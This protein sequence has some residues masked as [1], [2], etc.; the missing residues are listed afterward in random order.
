MYKRT[1]KGWLKHLDFILFDELSLQVAFI[2]GYFLRQHVF[3]PYANNTY[4][5]IGIIL[6]IFDL[7]VAVMMDSM[8]NVVKRGYWK[9]F[10]CTVKHCTMVFLLINLWMFS[11]KNADA[12]SRIVLYLTYLFHIAIGYGTRLLWKFHIQHRGVLESGKT[13]MLA[14]LD[15]ENAVGMV[16]RLISMPL[17]GYH[18]VGVVISDADPK[19]SGEF[20]SALPTDVDGKYTINNIPIV[21]SFKEA[22]HYIVRNWVDSV[23]ISCRGDRPEIR[24]FMSKCSEM[25]VTIHY[26]VPSIGRNGS[27][28]FVEK[29]GGST[30][31]TS[32]VNYATPMQLILKRGM[33]IFGGL[34]G[35]MFALI[36]M[37]IIGPKIK[38]ASPG[39][40]MY[41]S[42]RIGQ[43]GKRFKMNKIRSMYL[44]ADARK[45]S[46]MAQNR[47][48]DGLMF[49]LDFDPRII[50]NEELPD[51][52]RK[53][54]I[55]EFVRKTSLDEFPQFFNVLKGEMSLVGTRPP[56]PDEW[57][58]YEFHHR[59]RLSTKPGITGM[60]Q[61]SG[62]SEITDFEEVVKLDTAY[63]QNWSP[64]LDLRIL[65][66]TVVNVFTRKGA[67]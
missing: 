11:L 23:Y 28:Q 37:M 52:T 50:G 36:I 3:P 42:E 10:I 65:L 60:W 44:D 61:V 27:K 59:A 54:G 48:K 9:E 4:L 18:L 43:N 14:V 55:G 15:V 24:E 38:K 39:P 8:H 62:R 13:A 31:V 41:R 67:M 49:K 12:Y 22:P 5:S 25:A 34:V 63:I 32:S 30:V 19:T 33:D 46:L 21:C 16:E 26:H 64:G 7:L 17:D 20:F 6:A 47:V 53:T 1:S 51:G 66:K 29:V 58:K 56:T 35:S 40:I 2:L 57:E 45:A